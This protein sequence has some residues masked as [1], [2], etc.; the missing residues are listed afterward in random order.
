MAE[1]Q[2]KTTEIVMM[3]QQSKTETWFEELI[4]HSQ[5]LDIFIADPCT[6]SMV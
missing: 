6:Y 1:S 5:V 4:Y 3:T 2:G